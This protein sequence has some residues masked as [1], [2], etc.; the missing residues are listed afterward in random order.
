MKT[1]LVT[2]PVNEVHKER[3]DKIA[4]ENTVQYIPAD[5]VTEDQISE[6]S[7]I[8]GNVPADMIRASKRLELLQLESAGTDAYIVPGVL[9]GTT[10]L[11]LS[12]IHI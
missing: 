10:T 6:A 12:L 2:I 11:C 9:A 3:L 4:K 5:L 1:I 7:V 8:I